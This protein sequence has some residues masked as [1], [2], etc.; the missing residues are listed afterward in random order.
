[1]VNP[2][3]A[4]CASQIRHIEWQ[5]V[6]RVEM[7]KSCCAVGCTNRWVRGCGVSFYR[8]PADLERRARWV[9]AV[10]R[11][12]W[13]PTGHS[14]LCSCH[15]ISGAKSDDPLSPDSVPSV[16]PHTA[17]LQKRK[18]VNA[19]KSYERRKQRKR[20]C[21]ARRETALR[22]EETATALLQLNVEA[23]ASWCDGTSSVNDLCSESTT[24][25]L[26]QCD[27]PLQLQI[28][29]VATQTD[30]SL[31]NDV[32]TETDVSSLSLERECHV[33]REEN[34]KLSRTL[35]SFQMSID[36]FEANPKR[37]K[38]YTGLD[39]IHAFKAIFN[40]IAPVI[41]DHHL[42]SLP[43]FSQFLMVVIKLRLNLSDQDLGYRFGVSQSTVSKIWIK[44]IN[45]MYVRL[46]S[47]IMWPERE[48]L[49]KTMPVTF[50]DNFN[51]CVCIIDCFEVFCERPS[52]L[53]ARAQ[54]Y[55]HYKHHNTVKFLIAISPQGVISYISKG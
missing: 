7:V 36:S 4:H 10:N 27:Q 14:W 2:L 17:S 46:K 20:V 8:F 51:K 34:H 22:E 15:F 32:G 49:K 16:F 44:L 40:L 6:E 23:S 37:L 52:D 47:F 41:E 45:I 25:A 9:N 1:M 39:S 38:F 30:S 11:K 31:Q 48:Q 3:L 24:C 29:H 26:L 54:T 12:N 42:S 43:K 19:M 53:M 5:E 35:E 33:L 21:A 28:N 13:Q 18:R 55:S 50:R